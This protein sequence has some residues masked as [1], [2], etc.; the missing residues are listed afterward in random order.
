[1]L[2]QRITNQFRRLN[3]D[4]FPHFFAIGLQQVQ[5]YFSVLLSYL[6]AKWWRVQLGSGCTFVGIVQFRRT[7]YSRISIG[8]N[9]RFLSK[10][11]SNLH[12]L[13][14]KCLISTGAP[15]A[16]ILIGDNVGMSGSV[17][18]ASD[19][20]EIGNRVFIGANSTISDTD[21][22]SLDHRERSPQTYFR[23]AWVDR[24]EHIESGP[25]V[26][27]DDVFIGMHT[28]IL[29]GVCIGKGT[30]VG[31]GSVVASDLPAY[32]V[33]AG[34]PARVLFRLESRFPGIEAPNVD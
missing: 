16:K 28:I 17:I 19:S 9:C 7:P 13:N 27:G 4:S 3:A 12:G 6:M 22:H 14:R 25:I 8:N 23:D 21:S 1:M 10:F 15:T 32:C 34:H 11:S 5:Q 18:F 24:K 30:V 20:V 29:K 2:V 26:I 33:A 31:A